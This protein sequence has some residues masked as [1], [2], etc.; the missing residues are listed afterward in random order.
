MTASSPTA[1]LVP[2][3]NQRLHWHI[4]I[5]Q[6]FFLMHDGHPVP[7]SEAFLR[8]IHDLAWSGIMGQ[9]DWVPLANAHL[10]DRMIEAWT[11][12]FSACQ[13]E[14]RTQ[15][16]ANLKAINNDLRFCDQQGAQAAR[17]IGVDLTRLEVGPA[18]MPMDHFPTQR[19]DRLAAVIPPEVLLAAFRVTGTHFH[20]GMSCMEEAIEVHDT[21]CAHLPEIIALGDHSQGE[22]LRAYH[23]VVSWAMPAPL[24]PRVGTSPAYGSVQG[25]LDYLQAANI[26]ELKNCWDLVRITNHG[27]VELRALGTGEN[28]DEILSWVQRVYNLLGRKI[29]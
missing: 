26:I 16:H 12:E 2:T 17:V 15:P 29:G 7:K 9:C 19:Y 25:W 10:I 22:R 1:S 20:I 13:V 24:V 6:E 21:L 5:E 18:N 4:G 28:V 23:Q 14:V 11:H 8:A 27:T 3:F